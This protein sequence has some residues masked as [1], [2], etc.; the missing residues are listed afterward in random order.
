TPL[1]LAAWKGHHT[2]IEELLRHKDIDVNAADA[3]GCSPLLIAT[4]QEHIQV[5]DQIIGRGIPE[6]DI[7]QQDSSGCSPLHAGVMNGDYTIIQPDIVKVL[8]TQEGLDVNGKN[9]KGSTPLILA[10]SQ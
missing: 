7:N 9:S 5:V 4:K 10:L 2:L 3:T 1:W 6:M 8:L